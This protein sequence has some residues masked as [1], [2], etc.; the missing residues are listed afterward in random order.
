MNIFNNSFQTFKVQQR[1]T[2]AELNNKFFSAACR[3][4]HSFNGIIN[5]KHTAVMFCCITVLAGKIALT[6]QAENKHLDF[7]SVHHCVP[8]IHLLLINRSFAIL[9]WFQ[10]SP[11]TDHADPLP[12]K[13]P[14]C[15][16]KPMD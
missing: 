9:L 4:I 14:P 8:L 2:S 11:A 3:Q 10:V 6:G 7:R 1:L 13:S 16:A 12:V 15:A 5:F